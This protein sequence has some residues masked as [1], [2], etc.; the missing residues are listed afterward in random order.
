MLLWQ[1]VLQHDS[2]IIPV[3]DCSSTVRTSTGIILN[4]PV[5]AVRTQPFSQYYWRWMQRCV[6]SRILAMFLRVSTRCPLLKWT[7]CQRGLAVREQSSCRICGPSCFFTTGT[8]IDVCCWSRHFIDSFET[9]SARCLISAA[10]YAAVLI[11]YKDNFERIGTKYLAAKAH[12]P[13]KALII[14]LNRKRQ[15]A[16]W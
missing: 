2:Y 8:S 11:Y 9:S 14:Q 6:K 5:S 16:V 1:I 10:S 4:I 13:I 7:K 12:I 15:M 3:I